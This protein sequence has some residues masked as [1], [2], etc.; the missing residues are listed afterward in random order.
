M[1]TDLWLEHL[2]QF[3]VRAKKHTYAGDGR[4][5]PPERPGFKELEYKEGDWEYRDS[6]AGFYFAPGQ[7]IVRY[8]C[9]PRWAMAYSGGM[10]P[11]Y[12]KN[13]EFAKQT[14]AF[15]KRALLLV[16]E[17]MPFRGPTH[18]QDGDYKYIFEVTGDIT[19]FNGVEHIFCNNHYV[20]EQSCMG[21]LIINK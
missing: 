2:A 21:G 7:E 16:D 17:S 6:Y 4:E 1:T 13:R 20:F 15:L 3:L 12:H 11:E 18:F 10:R 14:F 19:D 5:V 8:Q 9:I